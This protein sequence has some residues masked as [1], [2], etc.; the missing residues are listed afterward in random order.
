MEEKDDV[1]AVPHAPDKIR[2]ALRYLGEPWI[3]FG[4]TVFRFFFSSFLITLSYALAV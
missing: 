3:L 1:I 4:E 2:A